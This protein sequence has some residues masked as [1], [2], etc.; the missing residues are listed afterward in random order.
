ML[1]ALLPGLMA[2]HSLDVD[3][4]QAAMEHMISG[5]APAALIAGFL[6]ALRMKG[7]TVAELTGCARAMR[8]A[9]LPVE[10]RMRPLL[11]TCGTGGDGVGTVNISTLASLVATAAGVR[12]AKHGNRSVSSRCG[13]ADLLEALGISLTLGPEEVARCVDEVGIGFMFAPRYHPAMKHVAEVRRT[14]GVRTLFNLIGPLANPARVEYQVMGVFDG[15]LVEKM[16]EALQGLGVRRA[17]VV[18]GHGGLDEIALS[19]VTRAVLLDDGGRRVFTIDPQTL[20]MA[21]APLEALVGGDVADNLRIASRVL[22]GGDGPVR[23]AVVINAAGALLA[24]GVVED[25]SEGVEK[26]RAALGSGAAR[27]R[28]QAWV[29]MSRK[30]T[31]C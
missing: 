20:G 8:A 27:E 31:T 21:L 26:S 6:V 25:L 23:D 18:H 1:D 13:S 15:D 30:L 29:E 7:E 14:L 17:L 12:V 24:A 4:A 2:G 11:D 3:A 28:L 16:A 22:D 5:D 10:P 9:A 19:G